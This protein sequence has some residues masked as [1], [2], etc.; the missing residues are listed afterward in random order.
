[1]ESVC[2]GNSTEGSNPSLSAISLGDL[3][4]SFCVVRLFTSAAA[5]H[6][7]RRGPPAK[8]EGITRTGVLT[9]RL[10]PICCSYF[11]AFG[12]AIFDTVMLSPF[13]SPVSITVCPACI[14]RSGLV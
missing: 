10:A 13:I 6:G 4:R 2:R 3:T 8:Y 11:L 12:I 1:M 7:G 5:G 9:P 14:A